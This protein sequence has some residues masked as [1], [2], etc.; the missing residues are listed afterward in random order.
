[1]SQPIV[2]LFLSIVIAVCFASLA[3]AVEPVAAERH[4]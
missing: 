3:A 4:R 2:K 1:V